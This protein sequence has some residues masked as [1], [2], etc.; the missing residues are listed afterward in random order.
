MKP[1]VSIFNPVLVLLLAISFA[2]TVN[3]QTQKKQKEEV[4][5]N[6]YCPVAYVAM[7][8]TIKGDEK[9]SSVHNGKKYYFMNEDAKKMFDADPSKYLPKYDGFCVTALAMGK[10]LESDPEIFSV[11]KGAT[12]LFSNKMA[13]EEFDKGP[14]MIFKNADKNLA[15]LFK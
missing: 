8:K 3:A 1:S 15:V 9:F 14:D 7:N 11:Y 12:Y 2:F 10:K 6:Q 5:L 4:A 13:K